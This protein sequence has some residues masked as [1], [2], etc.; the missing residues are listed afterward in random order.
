VQATYDADRICVP[1][2]LSFVR[3]NASMAR[4]SQERGFWPGKTRKVQLET[5][6]GTVKRK[7]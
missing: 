4:P 5:R 7:V 2:M 3:D 1:Q 6:K